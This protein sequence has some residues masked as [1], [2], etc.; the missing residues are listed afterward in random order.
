MIMLICVTVLSVTTENGE[1][2]LGF[3]KLG[4]SRQ[5]SLEEV[6]ELFGDPALNT[7]NE[8]NRDQRINLVST[9]GEPYDVHLGLPHDAVVG[10]YGACKQYWP[11]YEPHVFVSDRFILRDDPDVNNLLVDESGLRTLY[12]HGRWNG[13]AW[14]PS[15]PTLEERG[16]T[17][18]DLLTSFERVAGSLI[19]V[20]WVCQYDEGG[21]THKLETDNGRPYIYAASGY[22]HGAVKLQR[23]KVEVSLFQGYEGAKIE[24]ED[25]LTARL[26]SIA[27]E[28][29]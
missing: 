9:V 7:H 1:K 22:A 24:Y 19:D 8:E 27:L 26:G 20:V 4:E 10:A 14:V 21:E 12:M 3:F 5:I 18:P 28:Q 6:T 16:V 29:F 2:S 11:P 23:G 15:S 25:W 17:V 13:K